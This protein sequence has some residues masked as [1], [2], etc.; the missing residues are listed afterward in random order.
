[1]TQDS[2]ADISLISVVK[3]HIEVQYNVLVDRDAI[4]KH[5][6]VG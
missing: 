2:G 3:R 1:M 6:N 4:L 5:W